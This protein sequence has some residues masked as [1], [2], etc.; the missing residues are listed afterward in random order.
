[1]AELTY[2]NRTRKEMLPFIPVNARSILDVGCGEGNFGEQ[3]VQMGKNVWGIEPHIDSFLISLQKLKGSFNGTFLDFIFAR[4][5]PQAH[6]STDVILSQR[7]DCIVFNDVL[8]HLADPWGALGAAKDILSPGGCV[9][10]SIPNVRYYKILK[11]L[12]FKKDWRYVDQGILDRTHLRFFTHKSIIRLF[13]ASG[14]QV[15]MIRG[16]N[17]SSTPVVSILNVILFNL[18][19]G[20]LFHQFAVRAYP[21]NA[22][23][24]GD[25]SLDATTM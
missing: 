23:G 8:E 4:Q 5:R 6:P 10:A 3:L 11:Q 17:K 16:I 25:L 7:F 2:H 15:E 20:C 18:L 13:D 24:S 14:Y 19:S 9:V 21:T 12:L 1:M 22:L